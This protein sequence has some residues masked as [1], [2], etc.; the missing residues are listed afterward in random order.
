MTAETTAV[1]KGIKSESDMQ[2]SR[3]PDRVTFPENFI[4]ISQ[5]VPSFRGI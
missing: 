4:V 1:T 5:F 2:H 3:H